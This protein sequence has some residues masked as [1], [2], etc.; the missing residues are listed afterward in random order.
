MLSLNKYDEIFIILVNLY[1]KIS[2]YLFSKDD[3][4][5]KATA[6]KNPTAEQLKIRKLNI[7]IMEKVGVNVTKIIMIELDVRTFRCQ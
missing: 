3:N 4:I 7:D 1:I 2:T 5:H 6:F